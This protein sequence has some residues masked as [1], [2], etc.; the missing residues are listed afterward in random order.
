MNKAPEYLLK[1]ER[2]TGFE[3]LPFVLPHNNKCIFKMKA[4][5]ISNYFYLSL[6]SILSLIVLYGCEKASTKD[7]EPGS[8]TRIISFSGYEWEVRSSDEKKAGP[9]PNLFTNSKENVWVDD[10]GNL[11]LR[12][13]NRS[14]KWYCA[15]ITLLGSYKY[16]T[17]SFQT[18]T[19]FEKLHKNT[20]TGLFLYRNDAK[21]I[22]IEFS[23]WGKDVNEVAQYAIQPADLAGNKKRFNLPTEARTQTHRIN[24]QADAILFSSHT[25]ALTEI[26]TPEKL[27]EKWKFSG[28][29]IPSGTDDLALKINFWLFRGIPPIE[30]DAMEIIISDFKYH[31]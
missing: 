15:G 18:E 20:V 17:Y 6:W 5:G 26:P 24:W 16:G 12:I 25:G 3:A 28:P 2:I 9:G 22:D 19:L 21:E 8:V 13:T 27:I 11:H 30:K 1:I 10:K 29:G 31:P 4:V 23:K 14:G 7:K